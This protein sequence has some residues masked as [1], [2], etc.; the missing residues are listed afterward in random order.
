MEKIPATL[1]HYRRKRFFFKLFQRNSPRGAVWFGL[2]WSVLLFSLIPAIVLLGVTGLTPERIIFG[3]CIAFLLWLYG[4]IVFGCGLFG[5][6]R[7][8]FAR[9]KFL[10]G[11]LAILGA[12]FFPVG[13]LILL[14]AL[15]R[16]KRWIFAALGVMSLVCAGTA[17]LLWPKIGKEA[18]VFG[19]VGWLCLIAFFVAVAGFRDRRKLATL[20]LWPLVLAILYNVGIHVYSYSFDD[21]LIQGR[22][23]LSK[24]LGHSVEV[25]E[26]RLREMQGMPVN[27][28]PLKSLI[29][30]APKQVDGWNPL[31]NS[32]DCRRKAEEI[33]KMHPKFLESLDAYLRLPVRRIGH[34]CPDETL[35]SILLPEVNPLRNAARY[36]CLELAASAEDRAKVLEYNG[37]LERLR[38]RLLANPFLI[39]KLVAVA[40]EKMRIAVLAVPLAAGTLTG[41]D[42]QSVLVSGVDWEAQLADAIGGEAVMFLSFYEYMVK[43]DGFPPPL[44][45]VNGSFK[46]FSSKRMMLP[47]EVIIF[48]KRDC[49]FA[50]NRFRETLELVLDGELTPSE[51]SRQLGR[52]ESDRAIKKHPLALMLLASWKSFYDRLAT[53]EDYCRIAETAVAVEQYRKTHGAFPDSLAFLP[54]MPVDSLSG[55]P[56]IYQHGLLEIKDGPNKVWTRYGYRLYACDSNGNDPGWR[57]ASNAFVVLQAGKPADTL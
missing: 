13:V 56:F 49:R 36:L 9:W 26:F 5:M 2:S 34:P 43:R 16:Q 50:L 32:E 12:V 15:V 19:G 23:E 35:L 8:A 48:F 38:D 24:L 20:S 47:V 30:D 54:E 39:S 17:W 40:V 14:A 31:Q 7:I 37:K 11:A 22:A 27:A 46:S 10:Y 29:A 25:N 51:R 1:K 3:V 33:R 41:P 44:N 45:L 52:L 21:E 6:L 4:A 53:I 42:W 28:E 55:K 57:K 18:I